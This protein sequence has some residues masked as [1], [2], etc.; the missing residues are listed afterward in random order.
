MSDDL[1][2]EAVQAM[3]E[4]KFRIAGDVVNKASA[5]LPDDQRSAIRWLHAHASELDLSLAD[6][7][8][9][10]RYDESVVHKVFHGRYEGNLAN[11]VK[12]IVA[13]RALYEER[14]KGKQLSFIETALARR[15]WQVCSASLEYQRIGF[16][17]GDTQ[18]GKSI[19]LIKFRDD[20]N[21]GST[22]Y[23]SMPTGGSLTLFLAA[24]AKAL[25][26]SPQQKEKELIRRI[27]EA[28]DDR[29]LLIVDEAH[30][31]LYSKGETRG[32][33]T[34]EFIRELFDARK[35]GVVICGTNVFRDEMDTGRF[36][37]ILKQ[38]KRRRL[39]ALQLPSIPTGTDLNLFAA[40][41]A[42]APADGEALALQSEVIRDEGLGFWLTLLRMAAKVCAT[43][44]SRM[45][46]A[47]VIRAHA[48]L[49]ELEGGAK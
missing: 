42:L 48:G 46:W 15:V 43:K 6:V 25:R 16:I 17:F 2:S 1:K 23:V 5:E 19:A 9:L 4:R 14:H 37:G 47:G 26:I 29:M 36:A 44:K 32:A 38:A 10:I 49:K 30:Q 20:H 18:I 27:F 41:Y 12:E 40:A 35:C 24:L 33:R 21:H 3:A 45:T 7:G 28:F 13:G 39:V 31:C 34:I 11:V 22:I 8:K